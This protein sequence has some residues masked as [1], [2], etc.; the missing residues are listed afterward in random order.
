MRKMAHIEKIAALEPIPS[1]DKIEAAKILGWNVVL[2]KGRHQAGELVVYAEIDSL[3]PEKPEF[4]FLRARCFKDTGL[5]KGFRIKTIKLRGIVSQG[6]V[7]KIQSVLPPGDYKEG[8][9]V[10]GLIGVEEYAPPMPACLGGIAKGKLPAFIPKTDETRIQAVP[11]F[12]NRHKGRTFYMT[13]KLDGTSCT[14]Y[15]N[16]GAFGVCS[17]NLELVESTDNTFWKTARELGL[18]NKLKAKGNFAVQGEL[19]GEGIQK[20]RYAVHGH[21]LRAFQVFDIAAGRYLD[22]VTFRGFCAELNLPTVP[23]LGELK[24]EHGVERL[25]ELS[26]GSSVLNPNCKQREGIVL[27]SVSEERDIETGRASFKVVNPLYLLMEE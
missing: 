19:I 10:S 6:I 2:E 23:W 1:A 11:E 7:F 13:E 18:E 24:L 14:V 27:R 16:D 12:L 25:V 26:Q 4:E 17:H 20:N 21:A 9:D 8:D 15:F 3:L 22:S 5:Q